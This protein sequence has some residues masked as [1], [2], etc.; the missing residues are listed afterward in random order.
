MIEKFGDRLKRLRTS[1]KLSQDELAEMLN[2]S[3]QVISRYENNQRTP[4]ITTASE[5]AQALGVSLNYLLGEDEPGIKCSIVNEDGPEY[6]VRKQSHSVPVLG[7]VPAGIPLEAI[8]EIIDYEEI[9]EKVARQGEFF[10]LMINGD[11]MEPRICDGD[12]VIVR[13]QSDVDSGKVA[14]V[15]INGCDATCKKVVKHDDGISLVS[16]NTKYSPR[17]FTNKEVRD[18]PVTIIGRVAELRAK[19]DN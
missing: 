12:V 11:S 16:T 15:L 13:K 14:I 1:K 18:L 17:F 3:K 19:F 9:S 10:A 6:F 4:K 2:T 8:E 7:K 5:Y